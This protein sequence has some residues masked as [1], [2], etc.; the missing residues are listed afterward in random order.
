MDA[1]SD[2]ALPVSAE[3]LDPIPY[4]FWTPALL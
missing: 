3:P 2:L 4:P 1:V